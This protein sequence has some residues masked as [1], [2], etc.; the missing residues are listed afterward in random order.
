MAYREV[1]VIEVREVLRLWGLGRGFRAIAF[2]SGIDRKTVRRYIGAAEQAG[3]TR[4][5]AGEE[6]SEE[7]IGR[8]IAEV[9]SS[10]PQ[11]YGEAW[12]ICESHRTM[13]QEWLK[14]KL[15]LT[16]VRELL[17]RQTGHV[18]PYR[19]LH[20]FAVQEL[21]F[22]NRRL[23]VRVDD[24]KPGEEL[25]VD[26][27]RMGSLFDEGTGRQRLAWALIFTACY[28]RHQFVWLTF[29]Q[30]LEDVIEGFEK[31]WEFFG[32]VFRVVIPDNMKT[33]V[34]TADALAPRLNEGFLEYAQ[35]RGFVIDPARVRKPDDKPRVERQVPYVRESFF[36][37]ESFRGLAEA[38]ERAEVWCRSTAGL[39]VHGTTQRRPLDVF[40]AEEKG[41][42][43]PA[44]VAPYDVP[45]H[46]DVKA[47]IDH[48]VRVDRALYSVPT[49][50]VGKKVH[51]RA[52]RALVRISVRGQLIKTH[53]RQQ[54]GGRS[55]DPKDYPEEK[56]IYATRNG[57]ALLEQAKKVG[58]AC[59]QVA[60][61]LLAGPLPWTRMRHAYRL[62]GLVR[63]Y[64]E[65]RVESACQK[66]LESDAVDVMRI[67]RMLE[68][69]LEGREAVPQRER[70][71][72]LVPFRFQRSPR[73]FATAGVKPQSTQEGEG[74]D[75]R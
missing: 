68:R 35:T 33:I 71:G 65:M 52:D 42:L 49:A 41:R 61:T 50:W 36:A 13:L 4:E 75:E 74:D 21:G 3:L 30:A 44:P 23:T 40:E 10:G 37:G 67:G 34:T 47:G 15:R 20:R 8:V 54:A 14:K 46:A 72:R 45:L 7:L 48:H 27:G 57:A 28:S 31:A 62:L 58:G 55:T 73:E 32:G 69:G 16:K 53:P 2:L 56:A 24:G 22:G 70:L 6:I 63:T 1:G 39:R 19:T 25:Q 29:S 43:L 5:A 26:F 9:C 59:G 66:V 60:D 12:G 17:T 18:V 38:R 64:G 11:S 51:V